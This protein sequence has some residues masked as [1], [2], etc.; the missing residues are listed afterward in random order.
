MMRLVIGDDHPLV[1]V[2]LREVLA[3][4]LPDAEIAAAYTLSEVV[5][6]L[7]AGAGDVDLVLLDLDMPGTKGFTG[8][9]LLMAQFPIVPV[10]IL[11]ATQDADTVGRAIAYGAS[12]YIP[13]SLTPQGMAEAIS[14]VLAGETW[15]PDPVPPADDDSALAGR[16][17]TLSAQQMRILSMIVDGKLNKQIAGELA[18]AE[19]TVKVHVST[20]L[21]KLGVGTRTQAAVLVERLLT[22]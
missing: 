5:A 14:R 16:I 11:S 20:I 15:T 8:L 17:A 19:Q 22:R 7:E 12:G 18:I 3:S 9:F 1:Q 13:K 6:E 10:A 21:R 2:A 4:A